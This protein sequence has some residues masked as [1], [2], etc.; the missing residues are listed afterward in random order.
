M[1]TSIEN[2]AGL[3]AMCDQIFFAITA[4][5]RLDKDE[6]EALFKRHAIVAP[7]VMDHWEPW[8]LGLCA[9]IAPIAP[10]HWMPMAGAVEAGLSLEHGARGLRSLFVS[11]PSD[12]EVTRVRVLGAVV[13]RALG[14]ILAAAQRVDREDE[15]LQRALIASLGLPPDDQAVLRAET[16]MSVDDVV[17]P[18]WAGEKIVA[19]IVRGG[20][21]AALGNGLDPREEKAINTLALK[22]GLAEAD[23]A[24]LAAEARAM[25][26]SSLPFGEACVDAVLYMLD[27]EPE[28]QRLLATAALKLT[29][30]AVQRSS[31]TKAVAVAHPVILARKYTL[32]RTAREAVLGLAWVAAL[33]TNPT[34]T[35]RLALITQHARLAA[36]LHDGSGGRSSRD[37]VEAH[38]ELALCPPV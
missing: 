9:S 7:E 36:D 16:P 20:F 25:V 15:M 34:H 6:L 2:T 10:P 18:T 26:E 29:L 12:K 37:V 33:R 17:V 21:F 23:I 24:G 1:T 8:L 35:R 22:L 38:L 27:G 19:A 3:A 32:D 31:A 14:A 30:P 13:V 5:R 4:S 28:M 11:A